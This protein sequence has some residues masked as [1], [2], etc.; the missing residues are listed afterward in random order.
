MEVWLI[1]PGSE[2][3]HDI[4]EWHPGG[5]CARWEDAVADLKAGDDAERDDDPVAEFKVAVES[6]E[7]EIDRRGIAH[8]HERE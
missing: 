5:V 2:F 6:D 4:E 1:L 3:G 7:D 8:C